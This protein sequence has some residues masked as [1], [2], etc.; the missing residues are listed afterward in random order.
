M[1]IDAEWDRLE[2][3]FE[4]ANESPLRNANIAL[5]ER[6]LLEFEQRAGRDD[7]VSAPQGPAPGGKR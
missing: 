4:V 5:A 1:L 2:Q 6:V 3:V 7:L